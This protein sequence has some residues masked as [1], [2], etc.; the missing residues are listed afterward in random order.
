MHATLNKFGYPGT[1]VARYQHWCVLL[2]PQQATLGALVLVAKS[3]AESFPA[4]PP[5]AFTELA[6]VT[7]DIESGLKR[8]M[9]YS[10]INY[11]MLMMVDRQVHFHVLPRYDSVRTFGGVPFSDPGWPGVPDLKVATEITDAVRS[12]LLLS[13][14]AAFKHPC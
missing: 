7:A 11:I 6:V 2:R 3:E 8:F 12:D 9:P 13:L 4:L 14:Q 1:V 10:K 5:E